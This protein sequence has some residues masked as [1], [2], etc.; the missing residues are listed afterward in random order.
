MR[1]NYVL[2]SRTMSG[3]VTIH[4]A[5]ATG[6]PICGAPQGLKTVL[7]ERFDPSVHPPGSPTQL[8]T[9]KRCRVVDAARSEK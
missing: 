4:L 8:I 9:C 3:K 6:D 7:V 2:E 5:W 1:A